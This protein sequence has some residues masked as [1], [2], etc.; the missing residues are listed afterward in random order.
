MSKTSDNEYLTE[1]NYDT[2]SEIG[3]ECEETKELD[4]MAKQ[5][6]DK[7]QTIIK[8]KKRKRRKTISPKIR[9]GSARRVDK[10]VEPVAVESNVEEPKIL[11]LESAASTPEA[12]WVNNLVAQFTSMA[13]KLT[14]ALSQ[15]MTTE[16]TSLKNEFKSTL[17]KLSQEILDLKKVITEKDET[18]DKLKVEIAARDETI[19]SLEVTTERL[20]RNANDDY[21]IISSPHFESLN[22]DD[23]VKNMCRTFEIPVNDME[24]NAEWRRFGQ[25][26]DQV[27]VRTV[28]HE[29]KHR[30][31]K[32]IRGKKSSNYFI[33][34]LLTPR[35]DNIF[36]EARK[37]KSTHKNIYSVYTFRGQ[38]FVKRS[39][40]SDPVHIYDVQDLRKFLPP[41][42]TDRQSHP[43]ANQ[44]PGAI[45]V[46]TPPPPL[47]RNQPNNTM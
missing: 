42:D 4:D 38:V 27:L 35:N 28:F 7:G 25:N 2:D 29:I 10:S 11:G 41:P 16:I 30:L 14:V 18:I 12:P 5:L 31:F 43:R 13:E 19:K 9:T 20:E 36:Y 47:R 23:C 21:V 37:H 24:K 3:R 44:Y 32:K 40:T 1:D 6:F 39:Q 8:Q 15:K 33:S 34:E 17:S 22:L 45:D 46:S 26:G